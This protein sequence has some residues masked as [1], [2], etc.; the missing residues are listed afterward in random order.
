MV[1]TVIT[2]NGH[3]HQHLYPWTGL[4]LFE[5]EKE[6]NQYGI[7]LNY[8][9]ITEL[10]KTNTFL[11]NRTIWCSSSQHPDEKKFIENY[12]RLIQEKNSFIVSENLQRAHEDKGF[13]YL[14]GEKYG[15]NQVE[16]IYIDNYTKINDSFEGKTEKVVVKHTHG[17]SSQG[18]FLLEKNQKKY[19][20]GI[21]NYPK[22]RLNIVRLLKDYF[23]LLITKRISFDLYC[24]NKN[25]VK[26]HRNRSLLVQRFI[27][28][29]KYDYKVL[30]F[31]DRAVI[32]KRYIKKRDFKASGSGLFGPVTNLNTESLQLLNEAKRT[33][34]KL[35]APFISIDFLI[36]KNT[37]KIIEYQVTH[38]GPATVLMN[39]GYFIINSKKWIYINNEN[40]LEEFYSY[41]IFNFLK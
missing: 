34:E 18:V 22:Q 40:A 31:Y 25:Y 32:L 38:F 7:Q 10:V 23:G 37:P 39:P 24:E 30:V 4:N 19:K 11:E 29:L 1:L 21:I 3:L 5:L 26:K 2:I 41:A 17:S 35:D 13:A 15:I 33:A 20:P 9:E 27:P 28:N 36:D 16:S 12:L 14:L 8:E 6:F